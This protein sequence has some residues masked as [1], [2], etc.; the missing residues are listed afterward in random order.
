MWRLGPFGQV[1]AGVAA[2]ICVLALICVAV[3]LL[4]AGKP[5]RPRS[6]VCPPCDDGGRL[7]G[8]SVIT[9]VLPNWGHGRRPE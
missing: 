9:P 7:N 2:A 1:L 4:I 8:G 3:A 6:A 5:H